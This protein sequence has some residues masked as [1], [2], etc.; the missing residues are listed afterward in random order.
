MNRRTFLGRTGSLLVLAAALSPMAAN[1]VGIADM[2]ILPRAAENND[3]DGVQQILLRGD[4]VDT[5]GEDNRAALSFA[6]GNGNMAM[7]NLLLEHFANPDHRDRLGNTAM[8]WAAANG[9]SDVIK[10]LIQAKGS[11]DL[12]NRSGITPLMLAIGGNRRD[13]VRVLVEAGANLKIQDFTGHDA[14]SWAQ[15]KSAILAL[16]KQASAH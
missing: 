6:A 3:M 10:R 4:V 9:H 12:Q 11:I 8:H 7:L 5:E 2:Y 13:A 15:G 1:A 14:V 16:L